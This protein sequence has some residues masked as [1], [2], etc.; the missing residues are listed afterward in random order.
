[1][2]CKEIVEDGVLCQTLFSVEVYI[3][4]SLMYFKA[5]DAFQI[6]ICSVAIHF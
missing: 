4:K 6:Y 5:R 2:K 1:M 3:R